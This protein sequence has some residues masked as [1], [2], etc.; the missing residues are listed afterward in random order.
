MIRTIKI[1]RLTLTFGVSAIA[2]IVATFILSTMTGNQAHAGIDE[3]STSARA[4]YEGTQLSFI[5]E[6]GRVITR[7]DGNKELVFDRP[8]LPSL[9]QSIKMMEAA[10]L[11]RDRDLLPLCSPE[12][13]QYAKENN[14]RI[15]EPPSEF[16]EAP[17]CVAIP[18]RIMIGPAGGPS[19][20]TSDSDHVGYEYYG[21]T[22]DQGINGNI[23]VVNPS[24]NHSNNDEG[25]AA[26]FLAVEFGSTNYWLEAGWVEAEWMGDSD[27][28]T[29]SQKA[30][31]TD[32][33]FTYP[34]YDSYCDPAEGNVIVY[35]RAEPTGTE[36]DSNCWNFSTSSWHEM[37]GDWNLTDD[38]ADEIQAQGEVWE[39]YLGEMSIPAVRFYGPLELWDDHVWKDWTTAMSGWTRLVEEGGYNVYDNTQYYDFDVDN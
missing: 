35:I 25:F 3:T 31:S 28:H 26:R 37:H 8:E 22:E 38:D 24:V 1:R 4:N 32:S 23:T 2:V 17:G 21:T 5:A 33:T 19:Y 10:K 27:R 18:D 39:D 6:T 14:R 9:E 16:W 7:E 15:E 30:K 29:Y 13:L 12:Y 36:W 34:I 11:A 20:S